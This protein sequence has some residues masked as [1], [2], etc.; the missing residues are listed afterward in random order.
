MVKFQSARS[1][2]SRGNIHSC[3]QSPALLDPIGVLRC[4]GTSVNRYPQPTDL[5]WMPAGSL[6]QLCAPSP[7]GWN[8]LSGLGW[9]EIVPNHENRACSACK[10]GGRPEWSRLKFDQK[11]HYRSSES[12]N[13]LRKTKRN[14]RTHSI[15]EKKT[16]QGSSFTCRE[17]S[18][19]QA[20]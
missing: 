12:S 6:R 3:G 1:S 7:T 19:N 14:S 20:F 16:E 18:T 2:S 5:I 15:V 13:F 17:V 10:G 9:S 4:S 11:W 8:Y